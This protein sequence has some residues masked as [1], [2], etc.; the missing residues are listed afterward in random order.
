MVTIWLQF[1]NKTVTIWLQ[2]VTKWL[3]T[4]TI[5]NQI[6]VFKLKSNKTVTKQ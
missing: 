1:G 3:Q 6:E 5:C 4:V 2:K